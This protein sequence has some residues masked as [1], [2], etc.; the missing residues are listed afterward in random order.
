MCNIISV[1][2]FGG[3]LIGCHSPGMLLD[4]GAIVS[5]LTIWH[6]LLDGLCDK[7][8]RCWKHLLMAHISLRKQQQDL[9]A[10]S[11]SKYAISYIAVLKSIFVIV[12]RLSVFWRIYIWHVISLFICFPEFLSQLSMFL[13]IIYSVF[14]YHPDSKN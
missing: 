10:I 6:K 1:T 8:V 11:W 3:S 9:R 12:I 7:D 5:H 4:E 2:W 13:F 14:K